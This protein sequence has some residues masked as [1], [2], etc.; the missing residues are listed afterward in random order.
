MGLA[1]LASSHSSGPH[2]IHTAAGLE[3]RT[4][5]CFHCC[6]ALIL[7][8]TQGFFM[9]QPQNSQSWEPRDRVHQTCAIQ[10][11]AG[12]DQPWPLLRLVF[13]NCVSSSFCLCWWEIWMYPPCAIY[14]SFKRISMLKQS[15]ML[16][17]CSWVIW[18]EFMDFINLQSCFTLI[19]SGWVLAGNISSNIEC[20]L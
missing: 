8:R 13:K 2:S 15:A 5:S 16:S 6:P 14:Q 1:G 18:A 17:L 7:G 20:A 12:R 9:Q 4:H 10:N 3:L 19:L 11:Q